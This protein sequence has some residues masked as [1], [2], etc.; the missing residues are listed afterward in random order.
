MSHVFVVDTNKQPLDP[1]HPGRARLLLRQGK[2]AVWRRYPF[3]IRLTT[4]VEHPQVEPLRLKI[5]PGSKTTGLAIINDTTGQVV[6]A[7]EL[8]HRGDK[9]KKALDQ[10][11]AVRRGRRQR[12]TRYRQPRF[13][14]RRRKAGWL[15]PSLESR[16]SNIT[17]WVARLRRLAPI[18]AL[19]LEL[20]KF[21]LQQMECP[22][23]SGIQY[24]Q[25]TLAGYEVRAYLLEK[26]GRR[27]AYCGATTM[28]LQVEHIQARANGGTNR[29]SNLCLACQP[30]ND[31]KGTLDIRVFLAHWPAVLARILAQAK[32]PLKDAAA[33]NA[34]RWALY[35][36][37][38]TGGLPIECGSGGLTKYNRVTRGLAKTHW[39]DAACIGKSTPPSLVL[40]GVVPLRIAAM[41][42]GC[43]QMCLMNAH[44]FPRTK[45]K[46][47]KRV[48]GFQT[49]DLVRAVVPTGTKVGTYVGRVAVRASGSFNITTTQGTVQGISHRFCTPLHRCDG[50]TYTSGA[51]DGRIYPTPAPHKECLLPPPDESRGSLQTEVL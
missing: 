49:G 32:A 18:V 29:I 11:R 50:Y 35:E 47:A 16:V 36:R 15:P 26:W 10:R 37:L 3:T 46:G 19:S 4:A 5:D 51:Q 17:T 25:G 24:Q 13:A 44:G 12:K 28:P 40:A 14:N 42:Y 33:V 23:I 7:A 48:K 27:C 22:E 6:F 8:A 30:C 38:K 45:P 20:V 39:L 9:I 41:G 1:V 43:R 34:T 31:A 21:D 2:A